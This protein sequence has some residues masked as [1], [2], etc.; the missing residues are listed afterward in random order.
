MFGLTILDLALI[1][2]LLSYLIYGLRNGFMVTLGGI[3]GFVVGAVAAF[4]AVPLVSGWVTDS[5]WRLT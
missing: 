5:G 1:L 3:A 4:I 2:M